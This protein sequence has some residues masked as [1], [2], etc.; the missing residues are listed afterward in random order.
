MPAGKCRLCGGDHRFDDCGKRNRHERKRSARV[1]FALQNL[2]RA[3]NNYDWRS[4]A[5][6]SARRAADVANP[7]T[8]D[9]APRRRRRRRTRRRDE[10]KENEA[11]N[12]K[13]DDDEGKESDARSVATEQ[14][15]TRM[16]NGRLAGSDDVGA[17]GVLR[18][19]GVSLPF[20]FDG[21]CTYSFKSRVVLAAINERRA[22]DGLPAV[23]PVP[24]AQLGRTPHRVQLADGKTPM[25]T[26]G[27]LETVVVEGNAVRSDVIFPDVLVEYHEWSTIPD[28]NMGEDLARKLGLRSLK[29]QFEG[30]PAP[31]ARARRSGVHI[32]DIDRYDM[33]QLEPMPCCP[34]GGEWDFDSASDDDESGWD[35]DVTC[36]S[37]SDDDDGAF[38]ESN[39]YAGLPKA[40]RGA[41]TGEGLQL[42]WTCSSSMTREGL[43]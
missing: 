8:P 5:P 3:A 2:S 27:F 12:N 29:E 6:A 9:A 40:R 19:H 22:A 33:P 34:A 25:V 4:D 20:T 28:F 21:G 18:V 32:V 41:A 7:S 35:S 23:E 36:F 26:R 24:L 14:G 37:C 16:S 31:V 42:P 17:D 10:A 15:A 13:L 11:N 43:R 30:D 38:D 39:M 1:Y